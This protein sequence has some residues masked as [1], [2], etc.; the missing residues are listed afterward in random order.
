MRKIVL[1]VLTTLG[2][3]AGTLALAAPPADAARNAPCITKR[4]YR[5]IHV[6]QRPARVKRIVGSR[7]RV[8]ATFQSG[9]YRSVTRDFKACRPFNRF[10]VVSV[11][12]D[13]RDRK[14]RRIPLSVDTKIAFWLHN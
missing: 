14:F 7:G 5:R 2:V 10:S 3:V 6:G 13:N 8:S 4:E 1:A 11:V 12:F 9:G